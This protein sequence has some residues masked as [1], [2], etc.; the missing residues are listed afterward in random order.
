MQTNLRQFSRR[1]Q[2]VAKYERSAAHHL[3]DPSIL[4]PSMS[5]LR[6]LLADTTTNQSG[7]GALLVLI[8]MPFLLFSQLLPVW[9]PVAALV[10]LA[11]VLAAFSLRGPRWADRSPF[12][13]VLLALLPALAA[14]LWMTPDRT[15]TLSRTYAFLANMA[16]F[17]TLAGQRHTR[18]LRF[19][20][21]GLLLAGSGLA[22]FMLPGTQF[23]ADKLPFFET[24]LYARLPSGLSLFWNSQGF[25]TN[26]TG[27]LLALFLP[28]AIF[29]FLRSESGGQRFW[30]GLATLLIGFVILLTQSR[31]AFLGLAI[32]IPAVTAL[33]GRGWRWFWAMIGLAA[34]AL[35]WAW[36]PARQ[37]SILWRQSPVAGESSLFARTEL[38]SRA[39]DMT[40]DF[41]FTGV[42]LGMFEPILTLFYPLTEVY[43]RTPILHPH[44]IFL[45]HSAE[46]GIIGLI[47]HLALYA[48]LGLL[49]LR[50]IRK[51]P[52]DIFQTLSLGC[53]GSLIVYLVHGQ[54]E[55]ITYA[56]RAAIIV[57][58][59]WGGMAAIALH[60]PPASGRQ[61]VEPPTP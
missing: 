40:G 34:A 16:L 13:L 60:Q 17:W 59:L 25:H 55:V 22:L 3:P 19:A 49:L 37:V 14:G 28:P 15:V 46:M 56:P 44:N 42:G 33:T 38:W 52:A 2:A 12:T 4:L 31:G 47:A 48:I 35:L 32:A 41:P 10:Y 45:Q 23:V 24:R 51:P 27:G 18:W 53:L 36:P 9:L 1:L 29:L 5:F 39:L 7:A 8:A 21:A 30:A 43:T 58:A 26:L 20:P 6:H 61:E 11:I 50:R 57:W 54:F